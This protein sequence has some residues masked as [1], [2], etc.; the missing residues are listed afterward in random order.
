[1]KIALSSYI[2]DAG[3]QDKFILYLLDL[4]RLLCVVVVLRLVFPGYLPMLFLN[5]LRGF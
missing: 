4:V 2:T 3:C 5:M 1:M